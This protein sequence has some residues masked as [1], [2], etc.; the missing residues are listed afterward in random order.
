MKNVIVFALGQARYAIELRWVREVFTLGPVTPVAHAP[1]AVA[2]VVNYRGAIMTILDL[3]FL[4]DGAATGPGP[5]SAHGGEA[6]IL[7]EVEDVR[8]AL[9]VTS[10]IEVSTLRPHRRRGDSALVDSSGR[11]VPLIDPPALLARAQ[12]AARAAGD[13]A[14]RAGDAA[15][16]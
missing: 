15:R 11:A 8:A 2:G 9:R 12:A 5:A 13:A 10:V 3:S 7:V 14:G 1:D 4:I 16:E 6:A